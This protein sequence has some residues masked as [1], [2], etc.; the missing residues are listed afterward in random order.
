MQYR[1]AVLA[2]AQNEQN[3]LRFCRQSTVLARC[4]EVSGGILLLV[5]VSNK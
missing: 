2:L 3:R 1:I 4:L 5:P